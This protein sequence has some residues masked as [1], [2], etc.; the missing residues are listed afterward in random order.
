MSVADFW[1]GAFT[2][3]W[4]RNSMPKV[5]DRI[6]LWFNPTLQFVRA[7]RDRYEKDC[8]SAERVKASLDSILLYDQ[9]SRIIFKQGNPI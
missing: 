8:M 5:D 4:D 6:R 7:L 3:E 9:I 2:S 1:F